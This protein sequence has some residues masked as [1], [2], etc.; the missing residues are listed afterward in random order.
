MT[1][2]RLGQN[3]LFDPSILRR[4]IEVSKITLDDMV[5]EIG[6]G[7]GRLTKLLAGLARK[8]IAI[9]LD[10]GLYEK[11]KEELK[12]F[13]NIE[14]VHCDALKYNYKEL[15]PFKVVSNIPYYITTPIIF[16]LIETRTNLRS[17][18]LTMQKEVAQ[19]IVAKPDT[20]DYGVLSIAV[21]YYGRPKFEFIVPKGAF[22]PVPRVDSAV[23]H[24]DMCEEPAVKVVDEKLFFRVVKTA[25]SQR[26]KTLANVLKPVLK[27]TE[28]VLISS[29]IKPIRRAETLTIEEFARLS[30]LIRDAGGD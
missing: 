12:G 30:D 3:F 16:K 27:N 4:I 28:K 11:L 22:R 15:Q 21:Q 1:K 9:E 5:V 6:P 17:M 20:K 29:G 26:R 2:K 25:F 24:M 8:V 18:T 13:N 10:F 14:L 19:R 23:I 7:T